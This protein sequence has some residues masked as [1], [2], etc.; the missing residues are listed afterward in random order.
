MWRGIHTIVCKK[1]LLKLPLQYL[2]FCNKKWKVPD[3]NAF[4]FLP[5][6]DNF[7]IYNPKRALQKKG[8]WLQRQVTA[9]ENKLHQK[10]KTYRG[11]GF[12]EKLRKPF[13]WRLVGRQFFLSVIRQFLWNKASSPAIFNRELIAGNG[14]STDKEIWGK[15]C[16]SSTKN[17]LLR[18]GSSFWDAPESLL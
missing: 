5:L 8:C 4:L 9:I 15:S 13:T 14:N 6:L 3:N 2:G 11:K 16:C 1:P 12:Y 7:F 18:L 17:C 10:V